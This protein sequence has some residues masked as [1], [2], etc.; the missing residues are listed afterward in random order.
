MRDFNGRTA[1]I[2]GAG[3]GIGRALAVELA[4][5]G[6]RLA[7][8]GRRLANVAETAE[9]CR[10]AGAEARAYQVDV[11]DRAAVYD[12][13]EQ[14]LADFGSVNLVVNNAGI[15]LVASVEETSWEQAEEI[16]AVNLWGALY[17][18]KAF[19][20]HLIASG[21]G[22]LVNISS[23]LGL[24][25]LPTQS[26]Y[27]ATK[28]ALR[29]LTDALRQE[30][31]LS[32]HPV[33]VSCVYPG[34]V[35]TPIFEKVRTGPSLDPA[36]VTHQTTQLPAVSAERAATVILRG[37]RRRRAR[38]LIGPDARIF[39]ALTRLFPAAH[40][41]LTVPLFRRDPVTGKAFRPD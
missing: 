4:N 26:M 3:S 25:A 34:V 20:P 39:A 33:G 18:T 27:S 22:Y 5:R 38:I 7:L 13:A 14:V 12:H 9:L 29:G 11:A 10:L 32:G 2:T 19:L 15:P 41:R 37:V 16:F 24:I 21:E 30:M 17:G 36:A 35:R 40:Q 6:A 1:V 23:V 31:L 28:F 8:S